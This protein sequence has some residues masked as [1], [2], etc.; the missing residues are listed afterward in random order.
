MGRKLVEIILCDVH[1]HVFPCGLL[2]CLKL[3]WIPLLFW[4][5]E[6][7]ELLSSLGTLE[8]SSGNANIDEV[9]KCS[10]DVSTS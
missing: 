6:L 4:V 3:P 8:F 5:S 1:L 9:S 2:Y 7:Q 10:G